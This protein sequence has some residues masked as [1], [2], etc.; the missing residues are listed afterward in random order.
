MRR[1]EEH[2]AAV[3]I[4]AIARGKE[5]RLDFADQRA[6]AVQIQAQVRGKAVRPNTRAAAIAGGIEEEQNAHE[7]RR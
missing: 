1:F 3:R 5:A 6:A 2:A 4:Q 7:R